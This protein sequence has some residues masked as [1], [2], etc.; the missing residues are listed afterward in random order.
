MSKWRSKRRRFGSPCFDQV[1][2]DFGRYVD[3][4]D[5]KELYPVF[6]HLGEGKLDIKEFVGCATAA[7]KA[8][9]A[10]DGITSFTRLRL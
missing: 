7:A 3:E 10:L 4:S 5:I 2:D 9:L 1:I 6:D 8:G